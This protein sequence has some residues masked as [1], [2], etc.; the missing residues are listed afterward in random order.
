MS[1]EPVVLHRD[2]DLLAIA[3]PSGMLVHRGWADDAEVAIDWVSRA[4]ALP[5]AR[6]VHRLDRGTSGV[7]L[8]ALHP[9]AAAALGAQFAAGEVGKRYLALVRGHAPDSL[10]VDHPLRPHDAKTGKRRKAADPTAAQD[11]QTELRCLGRAS[12]PVEPDEHPGVG[13]CSLVD[14]RPLTGRTH[15]IRRHLKHVSHPILGD[16]RYGKGAI[17]RRYRERHGLRRLALHALECSFAHPRTGA[18]VSVHAPV[19]DDLLAVVDSLG[20][21]G[22]LPA[23]APPAG[24][25]NP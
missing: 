3:K 7:L 11:A 5:D 1:A 9:E 20:L 2:D 13:R 22:T 6:P 23:P 25:H 24:Q 21:L 19:P 16:V 4:L 17:N 14:A 8:F 12:L 10:L 18:A 15:Q